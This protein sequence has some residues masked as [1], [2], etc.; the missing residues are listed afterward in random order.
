MKILRKFKQNATKASSFGIEIFQD[1]ETETPS[2]KD[3]DN[4]RSC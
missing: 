1:A 4:R 3:R 2:Y